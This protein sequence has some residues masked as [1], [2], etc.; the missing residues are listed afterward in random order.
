MNTVR[1]I[2]CVN[3]IQEWCEP[4]LDS[5]DPDINRCCDNFKQKTRFDYIKSM[6]IEEM[7]KCLVDMGWDCKYC[8]HYNTRCDNNCELH[9]RE[10]LSKEVKY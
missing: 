1:C 7:S 2:N 10:W 4:V 9:C 6:N 3:Y 8:D 5:P